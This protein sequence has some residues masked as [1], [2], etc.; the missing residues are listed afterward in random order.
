MALTPLQREVMAS[1][2]KNRSETSYVAGGLV[3]NMD[4]PRRSDDID[5]FHDTDEEIVASA[6]LDIDT[7]RTDGF[8]VDVEIRGY[9]IVESKVSKAGDSTLIQWMSETRTRF[10]PLVRD[11]EWGARLNLVDLVVNKVLAAST[12]TKARDFVDLITIEEK[13]CR[14]GAV[15]MAAA[16]K[17]PNYS[18][19]RIVDE[20]RRRG[21]S[22]A[23]EDYESVKGLPGGV[24]A[25]VLRES[26]VS[27]LDKA[28]VYLRSAP[29]EIVGL[30]AV[31]GYGV[32]VEVRDLDGLQLRKAT[33][34]P[35]L[36][37]TLPDVA[38]PFG[39]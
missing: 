9:G 37:P 10:F 28:E 25:T 11:L 15:I 4:W 8:R 7:L 3:L 33:A 31:D 30:L 36:M 39:L 6:D 5:I 32:P 23:A 20:I 35:E 17:P 26:L 21:L 16:G 27:V 12:R 13:F 38:A 19:V 24:T 18:P 22:V 34:E 1:I 14:L 2:A 29:P